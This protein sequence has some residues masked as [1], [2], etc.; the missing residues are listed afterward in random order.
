[1]K[2]LLI[3]GTQFLGHHVAAAALANGHE[4]T[5]FHRGHHPAAAPGA[6]RQIYGDR[7]RDLG[8][9]TGQKWDAVVDTCGYLPGPVGQAARL[10]RSVAGQYIFISSV[11][12]YASF[13][14]PYYTEQ[15][16]LATLTTAQAAQAAL[17]PNPDPGTLGELYGP[18]K[19]AC[20]HEVRQAFGAAA[21]LVRPGVLTGPHD[22]TDRL[23]YWLA[24]LARGGEV[25]APGRPQRGIQLLDAR[26]LAAWLVAM[27]EQR[28]GGTFN[29]ASPP[30][31]CTMGQLLL[32]AQAALASPATL[33]WVSEEFLRRQQVAEWSELPLYLAESGA[34]QGFLAADV[35][36]ALAY[37]L[38][39]R[40]L[41]A[42]LRDTWA[43]RQAAS[44]P[45]RAGLAAEREQTLLRSWHAS[46]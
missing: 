30:L 1:M 21:L 20:E 9:L 17:L 15:A 40:P 33:T 11:A 46:A 43:W 29:V 5:L 19:A 27:A 22:P 8:H 13:S 18:L 44:F 24:R 39:L 6:V 31:A 2:V 16:P 14:Q 4:V 35:T 42:T 7:T 34:D 37:Q 3:G 38:S 41:A 10:L 45:L 28:A 26:D 32:E 36:K 23:A 12:A 25:L